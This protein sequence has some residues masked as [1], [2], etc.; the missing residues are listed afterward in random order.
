MPLDE[1]WRCRKFKNGL[2]GDL[3]LMVALL[4]IKDFAALVEKARVMEKMKVEQSRIQCYQCEGPQKRNVCQQLAG[5]KRCNNCGK[6]DHFGRD[7]PTLARAV[8]RPPV[9]TPTQNQQRRGGTRP[10]ASGKVYAMSGAEATGSG[11]LVIGHCLIAGKA[12]CC[13]LVVSTPASGL[14]RTSSL[15]AR[16]PVEEEGLMYKVNLIYLPLQE[17]EVILGMDWFFANRI[18]IDCQ[19]KRLLFPNSEEPE[20]ISSQG[21]VK[22]IQ[23]GAQSFIIFTRL[24]VE[25]EEEASII[26]VVHEFKD[27]FPE[28]V[29]GLPPNREVEF[30]IDLVPGTGPV[31]MAPYRMAPAEL[32]ELKKQIED[33]LGK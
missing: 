8:T 11:N 23:R 28:E 12:C 20:L 2:R 5:F 25:K 15:C 1:E 29:P 4:S 19:E 32:V 30:S 31:S 21:V 16:C 26:P 14:V 7:C 17:L 3:R 24:E 6:E 18:V 13:E 33:L 22:E 27:V 9:Q 10:Q